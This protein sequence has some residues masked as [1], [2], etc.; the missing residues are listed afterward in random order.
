MAKTKGKKMAGESTLKEN[1]PKCQSLEFV[2]N[3]DALANR[4]CVKCHNVWAAMSKE[5]LKIQDYKAKW[6]M[7][8]DFAKVVNSQMESLLTEIDLMGDEMSV[9]Q[10][11]GLVKD[12]KKQSEIICARA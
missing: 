10:L 3:T 12:L 5:E 8:L 1:C 4:H 2:I 9:D 11:T 7:A 6:G